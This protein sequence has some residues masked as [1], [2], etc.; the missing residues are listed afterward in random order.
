[1]IRA[2]LY[3]REGL[4]RDRIPFMVWVSEELL[5]G[6][7]HGQGCRH[8]SDDGAV[9]GVAGEGLG[10]GGASARRAVDCGQRRGVPR[11]VPP[12]DEGELGGGVA[13][14]HRCSSDR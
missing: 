14:P 12:V 10:R 1:M 4:M 11:R 9:S 2:T 6:E 3:W 8:A 7:S 5:S 13:G